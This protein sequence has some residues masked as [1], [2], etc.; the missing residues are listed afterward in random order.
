MHVD[1]FLELQEHLD[2]LGINYTVSDTVFKIKFD[3]SQDQVQK[4]FNLYVRKLN[5]ID[6]A[7]QSKAEAMRKD[8]KPAPATALTSAQKALLQTPE[9]QAIIA[10][11]AQ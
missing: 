4:I 6:V 8:N 5:D 7:E 9:A 11:G 2:Q 3:S 10:A 1:L